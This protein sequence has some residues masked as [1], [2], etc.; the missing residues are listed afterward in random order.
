MRTK[1]AYVWM[2]LQTCAAPSVNGSHT[3]H[4][5]PKFVSLTQLPN[6]KSHTCGYTMHVLRCSLTSYKH[7]FCKCTFVQM[8]L[9]TR[10]ALSLQLHT[11]NQI[12]SVF[13][14]TQRDCYAQFARVFN[15]KFVFANC[16]PDFSI[17]K[18]M[19]TPCSHQPWFTVCLQKI[20]LLSTKDTPWSCVPA[21]K[22]NFFTK[23]FLGPMIQTFLPSWSHIVFFGGFRIQTTQCQYHVPNKFSGDNKWVIITAYFIFKYTTAALIFSKFFV[24]L[25]N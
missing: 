5:E 14:R 9:Q 21:F 23:C 13:S 3:V 10:T 25:R 15:F 16:A 18:I 24:S 22:N 7:I 17:Q 1:C 19:F 11:V 8:G 20:S 4:C 12:L 2:G 6:L